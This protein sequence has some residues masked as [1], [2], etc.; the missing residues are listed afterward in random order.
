MVTVTKRTRWSDIARERLRS[1]EAQAGFSRAE[2]AYELGRRVRELRHE[3]GL[4][5]AELARSAHTTQAGIAR[6][7]AGDVLAT[8]DLLD[9]IS[10][11]LGLELVVRLESP[12][13]AAQ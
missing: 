4:S 6:I 5:Q 11:A 8:I 12:A 9:R 7:E 10:R 3:R 1:P 2:R 13:T